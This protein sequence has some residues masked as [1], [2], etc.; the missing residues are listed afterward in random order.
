MKCNYNRNNNNAYI[1][2]SKDS[3]YIEAKDRYNSAPLENAGAR[4]VYTCLKNKINKSNIVDQLDEI[5]QDTFLTCTTKDDIEYISIIS[6]ENNGSIN[7]VLMTNNISIEGCKRSKEEIHD[8][9]DNINRT[10]MLK[11]MTDNRKGVKI[12]AN[13]LIANDVCITC[14]LFEK[15]YLTDFTIE[16]YARIVLFEEYKFMIERYI[17]ISK[18]LHMYLSG[19][20]DS[21][22]VQKNIESVDDELFEKYK[23]L[24]GEVK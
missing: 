6:K 9:I 12:G 11:S 13:W 14:N 18:Y 10:N 19:E 7:I 2:D 5:R 1:S 24:I 8:M 20:I 21:D 3:I 17:R 15:D 16:Q 23:P 22:C 4:I